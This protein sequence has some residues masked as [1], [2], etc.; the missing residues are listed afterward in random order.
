ML[1]EECG[2]GLGEL[3][4]DVTGGRSIFG[5]GEDDAAHEVALGYDG[6]GDG[7]AEAAVGVG[8]GDAGPAAFVAE[9]AARLHYLFE[10]R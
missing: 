5:R 4:L 3:E 8:D 7:D 2:D 9:D 6:G 1:A 10:L